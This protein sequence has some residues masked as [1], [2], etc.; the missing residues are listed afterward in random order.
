MLATLTFT[1]TRS[2]LLAIVPVL[3]LTA[4]FA[5]SL[6]KMV[7]IVA[8]CAAIAL[9]AAVV[10][11]V[12]FA[13]AQQLFNPGEA[14]ARAHVDAAAR[15]LVIIADEPFGR[16]LG[17]AG[18][19]GQRFLQG[20]GITNE[21]W[22]LQIATEMGV[23]SAGLYLVMIMLVIVGGIRTYLQLRDFWLRVLTLG[24]AGGALGF[25]IVGNF[26]HAWENTVLSMLVWMLA[27]M[28]VRAPDLELAAGR[29]E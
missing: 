9:S 16:G 13:I 10:S 7:T 14:S 15:S 29:N 11:G 8:V 23:V 27:G 20:G 4:I 1:V 24:V 26:L 3:V 2:A 19:I 25:L 18:T 17:T 6:G 21:N 28:A 22:Y 5:R 12:D